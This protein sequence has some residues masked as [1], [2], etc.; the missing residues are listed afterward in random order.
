[1]NLGYKQGVKDGRYHMLQLV[2]LKIQQ[3]IIT[4]LY[5]KSE[6]YIAIRH[7]QQSLL[8]LFNEQ[9]KEYEQTGT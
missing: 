2:I 8:K 7:Y 9:I 6:N 5:D 1:M 3:D 4:N